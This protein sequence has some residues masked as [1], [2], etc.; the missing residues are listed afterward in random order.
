M[1]V[2]VS[3]LIKKYEYIYKNIRLASPSRQKLSFPTRRSQ[4]RKIAHVIKATC[5]HVQSTQQSDFDLVDTI[6]PRETQIKVSHF[7]ALLRKKR[8]RGRVC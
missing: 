1:T 2:Y 7:I 8:E 4:N 6:H 3:L 5:T